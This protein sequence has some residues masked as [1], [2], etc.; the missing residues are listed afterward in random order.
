MQHN[1]CSSCSTASGD[2]Q[3]IGHLIL[4]ALLDFH[5]NWRTLM[6]I[7][8]YPHKSGQAYDRSSCMSVASLV[9]RLAPARSATRRSSAWWLP[10]LIAVMPSSGVLQLQCHIPKDVCLGCCCTSVVCVS[11]RK[12]GFRLICFLLADTFLN[13]GSH[14]FQAEGHPQQWHLAQMLRQQRLLCSA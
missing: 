3:I 2:E 11:A 6:C 7:Q 4:M 14:D 5:D 12:Q 10:V 1:I 9:C 13:A 8:E